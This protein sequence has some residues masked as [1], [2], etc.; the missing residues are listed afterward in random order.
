M[1]TLIVP[2]GVQRE[3]ERKA[4]V[5]KQC[6]RVVVVIFEDADDVCRCRAKA[7]QKVFSAACL[8]LNGETVE[9]VCAV[10]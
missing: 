8:Q 4:F 9:R 3:C 6:R 5:S 1:V 7:L 10:P 2:G